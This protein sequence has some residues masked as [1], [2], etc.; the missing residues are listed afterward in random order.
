MRK[1]LIGS[2]IWLQLPAAKLIS[3]SEK[4]P[5]I[6]NIIIDMAHIYDYII[7]GA[8]M[9]GLHCARRLLEEKPGLSVLLLEKYNYIGGRVTTFRK[10]L[11]KIGQV[12]W[13][14]GAGRIHASH[15]MVR[16]YMKRYKL[17]WIPIADTA[18]VQDHDGA[19]LREDQFNDM[20]ALYL[21]PLFF[22][23][24]EVLKTYTVER[25]LNKVIGHQKTKNFLAEFPYR[26]EVNTL[27]ADEGIKRL[28]ATDDV[29]GSD[30]GVCAEGL[31]RI[32][33][34]LAAEVVE[35][36]ATILMG[37]S[38]ENIFMSGRITH[39]NVRLN[40]ASRVRR[41]MIFNARTV[42]LALHSNAMKHIPEVARWPVLKA[43]AMRPLLRV[44]A[45]FPVAAGK[46]QKAWFGPDKIIFKN[47]PIRYFIPIDPARG[48]CMLSYTDADDTQVWMKDA[49]GDPEKLERRMMASIRRAFPLVRIPDPI[50]FKAHPWTDGCTY[51]LP[52]HEIPHGPL[53]VFAQAEPGRGDSALAGNLLENVWVCGESFSPDRQCWIEG[54]LES[55]EELVSHLI[56][57]HT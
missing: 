12:Q 21:N 57:R 6:N 47:N 38:V 49:A 30:F 40:S 26:A 56:K 43:L 5:E 39:V 52:G 3:K 28:M 45:V 16:A 34:E 48:I 2:M 14:N 31:G 15:E 29:A 25:L 46:G 13:E 55:A 42:I 8:G 35:L 23:P 33:E 32:A 1:S 17:H 22:L 4:I 11:P 9:A 53:N 19:P 37:H 50:Y 44:Y 10:Q 27:R 20:A 54:A 24:D 51:W 41:N 18:L 7:V 36:G